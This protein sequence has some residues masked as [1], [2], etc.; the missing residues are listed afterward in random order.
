MTYLYA[1]LA[2]IFLL[3][4]NLFVWL[5]VPFALPFTKWDKAP[6]EPRNADG[7]AIIRGDLP[8]WLS[9]FQTPDERLPGD[10]CEAA[11]KDMF[12]KRGKWITSW[13]WLGVRN[14][15]MGLAVAMGHETTDYVP[16]QPLGF[17]KRGKTWR[18]AAMLGKVR[19]VVGYQVYKTAS[20]RFLAA[21]V[22]TLKKGW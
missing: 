5:L 6:S 2:G 8:D 16:E 1:P 7:I 3:L 14:I 12:L 20:G 10:T 4:T 19:F 15:A 18:Y 22:F 21:P 17:W 13:Y 11:V 9:W